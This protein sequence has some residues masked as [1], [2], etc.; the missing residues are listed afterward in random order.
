MNSEITGKIIIVGDNIDTDQIYPGCYLALTDP[1]EIGGHCRF[2][3]PHLLPQCHQSG[4]G[5]CHLQGHQQKG[6]RW[7]GPHPG[8]CQG[9]RHRAGDGRALPLRGAGRTGHENSSRRGHQAPDARPLRQGKGG[10]TY[11]PVRPF[12]IASCRRPHNCS[13]GAGCFHQSVLR[14]RR[15]TLRTMIA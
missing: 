10:V 12:A 7:A 15:P 8:F 5:A 13:V 9:R 3:R 6:A 14:T 1:K 2:L 4:P 11:A